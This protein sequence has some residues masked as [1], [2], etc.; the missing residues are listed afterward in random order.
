MSQ[1]DTI[2]DLLKKIARVSCESA[3][4][5]FF[6][7]F[8]PRLFEIA[9]Y[10]TKNQALAE[11]VVSDVFLKVWT[12]R[13]H[14][15]GI[16]D[17]KGYLF[18]AVKRQSLNYVRSI[19]SV[20][21]FVHDLEHHSIVESRTPESILFNQETLEA[22]NRSIQNLP[23][24]CRLVYKLVKEEKLTYKEVADLLHISRKTVEMHVGNALKK[25]RRDLEQHDSEPPA[26]NTTIKSAFLGL[27]ALLSSVL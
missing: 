6:N 12:Q 4:R 18:V 24:K 11:E 10:Y 8:Y 26:V 7:H 25:I 27:L 17:V 21:L 16:R 5:K 9:L 15:E 19:R 13:K 14:L 1:E 2:P 20:P 22:I 23:E 3:F